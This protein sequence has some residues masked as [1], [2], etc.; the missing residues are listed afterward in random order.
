MCPGWHG[1]IARRAPPYRVFSPG[2]VVRAPRTSP[3]AVGRQ[4]KNTPP[5]PPSAFIWGFADTPAGIVVG[6]DVVDDGRAADSAANVHGARIGHRWSNLAP[7]RRSP[8]RTGQ[9]EMNAAVR[10]SAGGSGFPGTPAGTRAGVDPVDVGRAAD[11]AGSAPG[12]PTAP[13][14]AILRVESSTSRFRGRYE[15]SASRLVFN[16]FF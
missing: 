11:R 8:A 13:K 6:V 15:S 12:A 16:Y 14:R 1:V 10:R 2:G 4:R 7:R 9:R 5:D 3:Q